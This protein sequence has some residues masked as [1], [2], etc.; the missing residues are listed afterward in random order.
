LTIISSVTRALVCAS[1]GIEKRVARKPAAAIKI[2]NGASLVFFAFVVINVTEIAATRHPISPGPMRATTLKRRDEAHIPRQRAI[3]AFTA[4]PGAALTDAARMRVT[5]LNVLFTISIHNGI[6]FSK[7]P[8]H[9]SPRRKTC[10]SQ[11][12]KRIELF[13]S[14][15]KSGWR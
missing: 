5:R 11:E 15:G 14:P 12:R 9:G 13:A 10:R 6:I 1:A 2:F 8:F 4:H 7:G 3:R